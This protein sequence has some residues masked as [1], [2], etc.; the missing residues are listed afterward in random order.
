M[1]IHMADSEMMGLTRLCKLV[2][3]PG[4]TLMPY[5]GEAWAEGLNYAAQDPD[6]ALELFRLLRRKAERML[7][8]L[9]EEAA[10]RSVIHPQMEEAY[11]L[12]TW[13]GIYSEHVPEHVGQLKAIHA[14]W[15]AGGQ[16]LEESRW[17]RRNVA[18][19]SKNMGGV[20]AS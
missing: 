10:A 19:S 17:M 15:K 2:A 1:L 7:T 18:S 16:R 9:T 8:S 4:S 12:A 5:E 6:E 13:L 3:E 14:A 20:M 11:T